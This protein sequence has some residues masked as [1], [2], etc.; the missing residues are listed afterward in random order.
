LVL[1]SILIDLSRQLIA[2]QPIARIK[3]EPIS[4]SRSLPPQFNHP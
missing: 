2:K 4:S 3:P 1:N